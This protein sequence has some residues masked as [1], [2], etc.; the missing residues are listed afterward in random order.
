MNKY[1]Q[2]SFVG[3]AFIGLILVK[4]LFKGDESTPQ[5]QAPQ[6]LQNS[7]S[8]SSSTQNSSGS[9]SSSSNPPSS[10][11]SSFKDGSFTGS[12]EDAFYGNIQV[13]AVISGGKLTD[14]VFLQYPNDNRTSISVNTQA[15]VYL[16]QEALAAQSSKVDIV[17]G[18]SDSSMAFQRS[19]ASALQQAQL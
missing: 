2:I 3:L 12:V 14:V 4:A 1:L 7:T 8:Q 18:A 17:S 15:S 6:S 13:Q 11:T 16:K 9:S 19:L 10:A 5:I